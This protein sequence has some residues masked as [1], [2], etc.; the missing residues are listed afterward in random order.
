MSFLL[1]ETLQNLMARAGYSSHELARQ[2]GINQPVIHR[3]ISGEN[4]NP[5][6]ATIAPIA[7]CFD[8]SISQLLGEDSF[9]K[10]FDGLNSNNREDWQS[11][12]LITHQDFNKHAPIFENSKKWI[13][14]DCQFSNRAFAIKI[15]D[16]NMGIAIPK[17]SIIVVDPIL[18]PANKDF[19]FTL[20][21]NIFLVKCYIKK[22]K[23]QF[24]LP[25]INHAESIEELSFSK[26][27]IIGTVVRVIY[28]RQPS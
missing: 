14:I 8:I 6:L 18:E 19:V 28:G 13:M 9:S 16:E 3:L 12:P 5:T 1:A 22:G 11:I 7:R 17:E 20:N 21:N 27:V 25:D 10:K 24:L 15:N 26:D 2:T 23:N 4:V